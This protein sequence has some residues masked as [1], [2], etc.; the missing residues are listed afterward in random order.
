MPAALTCGR[1]RETRESGDSFSVCRKR[2][3]DYF[4]QRHIQQLDGELAR[5]A[6][7][8]GDSTEIDFGDQ[9]A[10]ICPF[11]WWSPPSCTAP[12]TPG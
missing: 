11:R 9:R 8:V 7:M 3:S 6:A 10:S 2:H 4:E 12:G 5:R 1:R